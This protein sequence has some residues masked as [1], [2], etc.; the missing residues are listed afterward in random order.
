MTYNPV[1][2][3]FNHITILTCDTGVNYLLN[4]SFFLFIVVGITI[5]VWEPTG[6]ARSDAF[7]RSAVAVYLMQHAAFSSKS[8]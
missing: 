1:G 2:F 8:H 5:D 4:L 7:H 3:F 6:R